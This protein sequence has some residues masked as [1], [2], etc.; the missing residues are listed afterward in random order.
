MP[1]RWIECPIHNSVMRITGVFESAP[2]SDE[3]EWIM[4][5]CLAD[6]CAQIV[7]EV[8]PGHPLIVEAFTVPGTIRRWDD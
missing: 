5:R 2:Q 8:T 7:T 1:S 6:G 4:W 3:Y